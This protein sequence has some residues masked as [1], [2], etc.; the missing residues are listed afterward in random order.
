MSVATMRAAELP[1]GETMPVLGLGTWHLGEG[2]HRPQVEI[3]AL[4]TGLDL[5]MAVVDTAEIHG[6]GATETLVGR[7]IAGRRVGDE[8]EQW[9]PCP[10]AGA[11]ASRRWL[12][13][14]PRW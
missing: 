11:A 1:S 9:N 14:L 5:G 6:D 3:D 13:Y 4:R 10:C 12:A 8:L 7:A 2:R